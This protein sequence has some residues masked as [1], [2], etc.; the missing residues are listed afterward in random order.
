MKYEILGED[1]Q[2]LVIKL[3]EG[4]EIYAEAGAM[5]YMSPNV[6][7]EAK[8]AGG[9]TG[10]IKRLFMRESA[11]L[12]TFTPTSG[13]GFV[14]FSLPFPGKIIPYKVSSKGLIAQKDAFIAMQPSVNFEIALTKKLGAGLFGGEGFILEKF[15]GDG[16]VFIGAAGQVIEYELGENDTFKIST[17]KLVAFEDGMEYDIQRV[18][19]IKT[20][21]FGGEGFFL[22]TIKGPGKVWIQ[23]TTLAEMAQSLR[24]YLPTEG[25]GG[26]LFQI[27]I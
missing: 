1:L 20:M 4:E 8:A 19:G 18:G 25:R 12:T 10:A 21:L 15:T 11:F 6:K 2:L 24:K 22:T 9:I 23:S 3:K 17:G 5:I 13:E 26:S 14:V 7:M 16:Y 27:K